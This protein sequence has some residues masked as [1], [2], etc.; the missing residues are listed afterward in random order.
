MK[1]IL[2]KIRAKLGARVLKFMGLGL[3]IVILI[4]L[5]FN[6]FKGDLATQPGKEKV[7]VLT[8]VD[9]IENL[10]GTKFG[11][12]K[13]YLYKWQDKRLYLRSLTEEGLSYNIAL[14]IDDPIIETG[15]RYILVG[16]PAEGIIYYLDDKAE[17][18]ER[19]PLNNSLYS[20]KSINDHVIYHTK[21]GDLEYVGIIDSDMNNLM[22]YGYE[23]ETVISY[24][25]Y[26]AKER[27]A[28]ASFNVDEKS[29]GTR[30]DLYNKLRDKDSLYFDGEIIV[31]LDYIN[32]GNLLVL[33]DKSL[34]YISENE[35]VWKKD[36]PLIRDMKVEASDI[37]VLNGNHLTSLDTKGEEVED[38]ALEDQYSHIELAGSSIFGREIILYS[39]TGLVVLKKGQEF[40]RHS[41]EINQ[42]DTNEGMIFILDSKKY[43]FNKKDVKEIEIEEEED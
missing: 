41:Q 19:M 32:V 26:P 3:A 39:D 24:D 14:N 40:L 25:Y 21:T 16:N 8:M 37:Y 28:V 2:G 22:K 34:Y 23:G 15:D 1:N 35:I 38:I 11:M 31:K 36:F 6:I 17:M 9:Q 13:D 43:S 4:I 27:V 29:I 18:V 30:L 5:S 42:L 7:N 12:Y 10:E 20:F 33:T